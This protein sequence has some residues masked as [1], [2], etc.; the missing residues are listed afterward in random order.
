MATGMESA[1]EKVEKKKGRN[2]GNNAH[3]SGLTLANH[4][5]TPRNVYPETEVYILQIADMICK[6]KTRE[7]CLD[8]IREAKDISLPQ[9]KQYYDAAIRSLVPD[10][11]DDYKKQMMAK[12]FRRLEKI[13]EKGMTDDRDLKLAKE[14]IAELNRM[15]GITGNKVAMGKENADGSREIIEITFD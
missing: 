7:A 5:G 13:V 6:G 10:D 14:A 8:Y 4:D 2:G 9:A 1:V 11:M 15:I 3:K 12:N